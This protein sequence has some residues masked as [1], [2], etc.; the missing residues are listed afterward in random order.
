MTDANKEQTKNLAIEK[1][2]CNQER[3]DVGGVGV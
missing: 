3:V 2:T 1:I